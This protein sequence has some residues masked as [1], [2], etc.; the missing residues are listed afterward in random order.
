M[1]QIYLEKDYTCVTIEDVMR[2]NEGVTLYY[3]KDLTEY[4]NDKKLILFV[5]KRK[6][7]LKLFAREFTEDPFTGID[8]MDFDDLIDF[9]PVE[10]Y[11]IVDYDYEFLDG[12]EIE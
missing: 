1:E 5:V 11:Q 7:D 9:H 4:D 3:K 8:V 6:S 10:L 2:L 12:Y